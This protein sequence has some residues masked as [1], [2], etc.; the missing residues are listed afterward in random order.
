M[1][2]VTNITL[3]KIDAIKII[4]SVAVVHLLTNMTSKVEPGKIDPR[5][6]TNEQI[7]YQLVFWGL[8]LSLYHL[9]LANLFN[10][11]KF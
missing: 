11:N 9:V 1:Y 2:K 6:L 10:V 8:G 5:V 3:L 7:A 4:S